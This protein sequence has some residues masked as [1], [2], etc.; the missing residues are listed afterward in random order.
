MALSKEDW[1]KLNS[2]KLIN[3]NDID[4][5]SSNEEIYYK[6]RWINENGLEQRLIVSY[7]PNMLLTKK[8]LRANQIERAKI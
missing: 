4:N 6:E 2:N 7:S 3:L 1:H 5:S 8:N